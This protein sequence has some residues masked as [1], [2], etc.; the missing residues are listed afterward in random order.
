MC[1]EFSILL[2]IRIIRAIAINKIYNRIMSIIIEMLDIDTECALNYYY[3]LKKMSDY[4][5]IRCVELE[6]YETAT[7][8]KN[9]IKEY[10]QTEQAGVNNQGTIDRDDRYI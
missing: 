5:E 3:H 10:E 4:Y 2:D 8:I 7:N 1:N 6:L 9:F